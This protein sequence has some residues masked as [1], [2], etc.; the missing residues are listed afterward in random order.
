LIGLGQDVNNQKKEMGEMALVAGQ[1]FETNEVTV[2]LHGA[3]PVVS[4]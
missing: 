1:S 4:I 2:K 3:S